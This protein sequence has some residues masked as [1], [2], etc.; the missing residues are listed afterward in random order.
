MTQFPIPSIKEHRV[1]LLI[2]SLKCFDANPFNREMQKKCVLNLYANKS[3]KSVFRGMV[4]PTLRTL[5]LI[6]GHSD[7]IRLAS[8]G[9]II[10]ESEKS[11][12]VHRA[13][14]AIFL[15]IDFRK[16]HLLEK[17][18]DHKSLTRAEI[19]LCMAG[20][21]PVDRGLK[22]RV[23]SWLS[24]LEDASLAK[25]DQEMVKIVTENYQKAMED[26]CVEKKEK[27]FVNT[28]LACFH[29]FN[30]YGTT[31]MIDIVDLRTSVAL[32]YLRKE[33]M[34]LTE[35]QFDELLRRVPKTSDSYI[36]TFGQPMGAEE[37]LFVFR[38]NYYRTINIKSI[39][40]A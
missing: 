33:Q 18:R 16:F 10:V 1:R 13:V 12:I 20:N 7:K 24:I 3:E 15:E 8:N 14:R 6:A 11:S 31:G 25:E 5:D 17:V 2:D 36:I 19:Y 32:E 9:K 37:R 23:D 29:S 4:I 30:R 39:R 26:L 27:M 40:G 38:G 35:A 21:H 34:I 22:E 28:L